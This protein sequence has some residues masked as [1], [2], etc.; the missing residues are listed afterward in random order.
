MQYWADLADLQLSTA[1]KYGFLDLDKTGGAS[2]VIYTVKASEHAPRLIEVKNGGYTPSISTNAELPAFLGNNIQDIN[3]TK[4][5]FDYF[6]PHHNN[7]SFALT[8]VPNKRLD[9]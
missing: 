5:G 8:L 6:L 7:W 2:I 1:I 3:T 4:I 9:C